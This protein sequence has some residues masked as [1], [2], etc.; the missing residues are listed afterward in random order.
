MLGLKE[1][2]NYTVSNSSFRPNSAHDY[3]IEVGKKKKIQS[4]SSKHKHTFTGN[5]TNLFTSLVNLQ[6]AGG[7][8]DLWNGRGFI[9]NIFSGL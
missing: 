9:T 6:V 8:Q 7:S 5:I 4:L 3:M 2:V 1:N